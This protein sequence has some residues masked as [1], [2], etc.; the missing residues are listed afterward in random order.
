MSVFLEVIS[1]LTLS[2]VKDGFQKFAKTRDIQKNGIVV[3]AEITGYYV[4]YYRMKTY[5]PII[6][7][8]DKNKIT[9]K[10]Q[11]SA[12]MTIVLPKYKKGRKVK[13]AY[14]PE[15]P[16]IF[17]IIPAYYWES[18]LEIFIFSVIAIPSV[19]GSW[20]SVCQL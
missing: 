15:N 3:N 8:R 6:K 10:Y 1:F 17:A 5:Y 12:G 11:S 7:F 9:H 18:I 2:G 13:T 16:E 20:I 4:N 14:L 19:I